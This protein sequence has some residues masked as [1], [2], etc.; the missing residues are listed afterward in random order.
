MNAQLKMVAV[1]STVVILLHRISVLVTVAWR[2]DPVQT[3][4]QW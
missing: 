3:Y 4:L 1:I 2:L